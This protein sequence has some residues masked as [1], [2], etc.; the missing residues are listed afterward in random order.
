MILNPKHQKRGD[1]TKMPTDSERNRSNVHR[2]ELRA[3]TVKLKYVL[4]TLA[5]KPLKKYKVGFFEKVQWHI[6]KNKFWIGAGVA[7]AGVILRGT[8]G[9]M[10]ARVGEK[11]AGKKISQKKEVRQEAENYRTE[12]CRL[13]R[14]VL[15][16]IFSFFKKEKDNV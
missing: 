16:F 13:I 1:N 15:E 10:I 3:R 6:R 12:L 11:I 4:K 7:V 8:G 2:M 9:E 14:V 5:P